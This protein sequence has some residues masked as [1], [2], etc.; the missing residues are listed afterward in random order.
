MKK[1]LFP[2]IALLSLHLQAH[3][4]SDS[5]VSCSAAFDWKVND[6]IMMFAPGMAV[7]FFDLSEGEVVSRLWDFGDGSY[8]EMQNPMHIFTFLDGTGMSP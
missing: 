3:P 1:I 4:Q 6:S 7:N 8:S 2:V 5:N